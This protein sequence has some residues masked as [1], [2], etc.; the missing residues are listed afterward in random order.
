MKGG[1]LSH[2]AHQGGQQSQN[3]QK[4]RGTRGSS[5][6]LPQVYSAGL[7]NTVLLIVWVSF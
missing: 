5:A 4:R 3:K 7:D 1:R 6:G 2:R